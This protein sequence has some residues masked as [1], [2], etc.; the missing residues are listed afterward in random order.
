MLDGNERSEL[1]AAPASAAD[2]GAL[3]VSPRDLRSA[4]PSHEMPPEP[5]LP[6]RIERKT[7]ALTPEEQDAERV[8]FAMWREGRTDDAIAFLER[9]ILLEKDRLW[10]R[11]T[12]SGRREPHFGESAP[13]VIVTPPP[14]AE[15]KPKRKRRRSPHSAPVSEPSFSDASAPVIDLSAETVASAPFVPPPSRMGRGPAIVAAVGLVIVGFAAAANIWDNQRFA[16]SVRHE[17]TLVVPPATDND[18]PASTAS[19]TPA[20]VKPVN[21]PAAAPASV[22]ATA[23]PAA[24]DIPPPLVP[25]TA[26]PA[27]ID[28]AGIVDPDEIVTEPEEALALAQPGDDSTSPPDEMALIDEEPTPIAAPRLPRQRPEPPVGATDPQPPPEQQTAAISPAPLVVA[29]PP[30]AYIPPPAPI[31]SGPFAQPEPQASGALPRPFYGADGVPHRET[32]SPAEY[33]A[34]LARRAAAEEYTAQRRALAEESVPDER[35]VI[36]RLLRR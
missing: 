21:E 14:V 18:G 20:A 34:L 4:A 15:A 25:A 2:P 30:P 31:P 10:K 17:P 3:G 27:E 8:A 26:A 33:E 13:E 9:E 36:L 32:L 5:G 1:N 28:A 19:V 29:E 6:A 22:P 23:K 24:L 7:R 16:T 35:R 12:L 11:D